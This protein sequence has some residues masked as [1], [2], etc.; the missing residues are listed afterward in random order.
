MSTFLVKVMMARMINLMLVI[1][2]ALFSIGA[3]RPYY[4]HDMAEGLFPYCHDLTPGPT[5]FVVGWNFSI[6]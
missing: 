1:V 6:L 5:L 3:A 4:Y 2:I